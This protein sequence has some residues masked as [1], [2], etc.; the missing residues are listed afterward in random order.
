[1]ADDPGENDN[2]AKSKKKVNKE[3]KKKQIQLKN[4]IASNEYMWKTSKPASLN[5]M[6]AHLTRPSEMEVYH[7]DTRNIT[8]HKWPH[9]MI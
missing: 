2:L 4:N 7:R 8:V 9:E 3:M 6:L 5:D 1:M